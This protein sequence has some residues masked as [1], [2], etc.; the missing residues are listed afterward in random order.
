MNKRTPKSKVNNSKFFPEKYIATYNQD[1]E[2]LKKDVEKKT[3]LNTSA[4]IKALAVN[5]IAKI[6]LKDFS[7]PFA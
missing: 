6:R 2:K 5:R 7:L 4:V 1:Y 3:D